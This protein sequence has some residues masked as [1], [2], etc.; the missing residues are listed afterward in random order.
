[1]LFLNENCYYHFTKF[2]QVWYILTLDMTNFNIYWKYSTK[3]RSDFESFTVTLLCL[4]LLLNKHLIIQNQWWQKHLIIQHKY[5]FNILIHSLGCWTH[6][7]GFSSLDSCQIS[8]SE[9]Q[10]CH[11]ILLHVYM[12]GRSLSF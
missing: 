10:N 5:S 3:I 6:H 4:E 11:N 1:M 2:I 9:E 8:W 7:F 12:E